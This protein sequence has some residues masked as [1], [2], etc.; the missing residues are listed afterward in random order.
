MEGTPYLTKEA[1]LRR[2]QEIVGK[3]LGEIDQT[4][5]LAT[6]KGAAGTIVEEG[7]FGYRANSS[8]EPDFPEAGV[9]LKVTPY[10]RTRD[11]V[12]AKERL[13]CSLINYMTEHAKSFE[14]SDFWHKCATMLLMSYEDRKGVPKSQFTIDKV[15]LFSFPEE[16]R[17]IV[18]QDWETIMAK[19]RRGEA[20][21]LSEGD[22][23]YL[24]ACTKGSSS[25]TVRAQPFSPIKAKQRAY[26]LKPSYMTRVLNTYI[27]GDAPCER[28]IKDWHLLE[29]QPFEGHI[30]EKLRPY[31]GMTQRQLAERFRI[32]GTPKNLNERILSGML[33]IRGRASAT[34]E[35][36]RASII[37]KTI[38]IQRNGRIIQSMSFPAF[39]FM[40]LIQETWEDSTLRSY[41]AP[42]KFLFV[43]FQENDKGEYVFHRTRFWNIPE[44]DLEEVHRVWERTV[45]TIRRGVRL[46]PTARRVLNDL[47]GQGDS[48]VAHVRPH[49]VCSYYLLE[50]GAQFGRGT[51]ADAAQLPDGRW[52]TKQCFWLNNSYVRAQLE[53]CPL[54]SDEAPG[55]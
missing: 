50:D 2:G 10:E 39:D 4:D 37:P 46:R 48:P 31:L 14:T 15:V 25:A 22:T 29:E 13:V 42:A 24:A 3:T 28:I 45:Q 19:V 11:G 44:E 8:S 30:L 52:M 51:L 55:I 27:F 49:S 53:A 36:Q 34:E 43:V 12:K 6:G 1:V 33:G 41:L 17:A 9:E 32:P 40:E 47:P 18:K 38:R 16:D 7:W 54:H 21:L 5:R 35:F 23:L 20:H 26:S